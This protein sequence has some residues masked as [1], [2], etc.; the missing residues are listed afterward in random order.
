MAP[1]MYLMISLSMVSPSFYSDSQLTRQLTNV[2]GGNCRTQMIMHFKPQ[3]NSKILDVLLS[4]AR[5]MS[6][7]VN[8]PVAN[9]AIIQVCSIF[10]PIFVKQEEVKKHV[11]DLLS[12]TIHSYIHRHMGAIPFTAP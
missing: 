2:F 9:T 12:I 3:S 6:Q 5:H 4:M 11:I 10:L 8:Y 1:A 7:V